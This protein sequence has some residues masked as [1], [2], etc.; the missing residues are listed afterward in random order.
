VA[1]FGMAGIG[2]CGLLYPLIPQIW[3]VVLLGL[4]TTVLTFGKVAFGQA[5]KALG[6]TI[7]LEG[8]MVWSST[9]V[10]WC[11]SGPRRDVWISANIEETHIRKLREEFPV[12]V[13]RRG[14]RQDAVSFKSPAK[15]SRCVNMAS[16]PFAERG[17]SDSGRSW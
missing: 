3:W 15:S 8:V 12:E 17:H 14:L 16:S 5:T 11:R 1:L 9:A 6:F 2:I 7:L 4:A 13:K 10:T